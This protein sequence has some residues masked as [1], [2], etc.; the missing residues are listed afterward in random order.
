[1]MLMFGGLFAVGA[2]LRTKK[3]IRGR[4]PCEAATED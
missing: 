3:W 4:V 1:M 2:V